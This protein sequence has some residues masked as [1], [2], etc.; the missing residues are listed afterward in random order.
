MKRR[1]FFAGILGSLFIAQAATAELK[2]GANGNVGIGM[3]PGTETLKAQS[4]DSPAASFSRNLAS[5]P[6]AA[7]EGKY[8]GTDCVNAYGVYGSATPCA[9]HGWGGYFSGGQIGV[10]GSAQVTGFGYRTGVFG[11]SQYGTF[12]RGIYG[13]AEGGSG[14]NFGLRGYAEGTN[15]YGLYA[16]GDSYAGYFEGNVAYTGTLTQVSDEKLKENIQPL[17][18]VLAKVMNIKARSYNFK[19]DAPE[20]K[21]MNLAEGKRYGLVAQELEE[22]FPE[23]VSDEVFIQNDDAQPDPMDEGAAPPE[24]AE[25]EK[26]NYKSINYIELIPILVQAIQEQQDEIEQLKAKLAK[27]K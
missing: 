27:S 6:G 1:I 23:L 24:Q 17:D 21:S 12:S 5:A 15:S 16:T 19:K 22:V 2:V 7:L 10:S 26:I 11:H 9:N 13:Y 14:Y 18:S 4:A 25:P 8:T 20:Y 3:E